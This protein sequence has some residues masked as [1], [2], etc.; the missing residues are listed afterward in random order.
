MQMADLWSFVLELLTMPL[1]SCAGFCGFT[2]PALTQRQRRVTSAA[3]NINKLT[4][5]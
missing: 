3:V 4:Q 1:S 2:R 5:C